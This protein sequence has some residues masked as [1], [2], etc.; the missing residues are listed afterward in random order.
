MTTSGQLVLLLAAAY[1]VGGVPF[2]LVVSRLKGVDIRKCGS[3]NVG[4]TNVGRVLG[5][6]WGVLVL[7]LDAAKG[8]ATTVAAT[9]WL[10]R[11]GPDAAGFRQVHRDLVLLGVGAACVIG[12]IAPVYLRF[13]GG[14]GVATSLGVVM[15]IY[16]YLTL[17]GLAV[18]VVWLVVTGVSRYVSLGSIAAAVA[19]PIAFITACRLRNWPLSDHAPL[20]VLCVLLA[21]AVLV[22]HRANIARLLAGKESKIGGGKAAAQETTVS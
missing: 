15:G 6:R 18:G 14:K 4:A 22:R 12:S 17:P 20:L 13:R 11:A 7:L 1:L 3:G 19:L 21:A 2:G 10:E 5:R 8:A 16:P 9:L